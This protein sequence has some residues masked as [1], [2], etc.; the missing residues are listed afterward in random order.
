RPDFIEP[1]GYVYMG[2]SR[3]RL[4]RDQEPTH[5]EIAAF[6]RRLSAKSGY[7]LLDESPDSKVVLLGRRAEGRF[8]PG[9]TPVAPPLP[10]AAAFATGEQN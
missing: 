8:L 7:L 5:E 9:R 4:G 6:A 3:Q 10:M 2:K 1:K